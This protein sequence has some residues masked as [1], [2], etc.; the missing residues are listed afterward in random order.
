M[1]FG[2]FV[3]NESLKR[4]EGDQIIYSKETSKKVD[5]FFS[6]MKTARGS[7]LSKLLKYHEKYDGFFKDNVEKIRQRM[8][9]LEENHGAK[10][11]KSIT[12]L[13]KDANAIIS[14]L[15]DV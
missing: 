5:E 4:D 11:N 10:V 15:D 9:Q 7:D 1:T 2:I 6:K 13:S 12:K 14:R 8:I 3:D